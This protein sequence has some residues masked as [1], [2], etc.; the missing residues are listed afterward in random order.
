MTAER[1]L[2]QAERENIPLLR[3]KIA[4]GALGIIAALVDIGGAVHF[5]YDATLESY[6]FFTE[7]SLSGAV[8]NGAGFAT[9]FLLF[10]AAL[11]VSKR[12]LTLIGEKI[13]EPKYRFKVR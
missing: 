9:D 8:I 4:A 10:F 2:T 12:G 13:S 11:A 3:A 5:G 1:P 7:E 6:R